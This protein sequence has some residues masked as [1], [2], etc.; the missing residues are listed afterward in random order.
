MHDDGEE[1]VKTKP[2]LPKVMEMARKAAAHQLR[3]FHKMMERKRTS[4]GGPQ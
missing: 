2:Y 4:S 1:A 3:F